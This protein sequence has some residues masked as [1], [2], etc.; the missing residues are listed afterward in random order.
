MKTEKRKIVVNKCKQDCPF[1]KKK[2]N[3]MY[4]DHPDFWGRH[5]FIK[6]IINN[7]SKNYIPIKCPLKKGDVKQ[8]AIITL[9]K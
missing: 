3:I 7:I 5:I 1:F 4:C 8:V 9:K 6:T 2:M